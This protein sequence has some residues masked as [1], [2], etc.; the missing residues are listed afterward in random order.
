MWRCIDTH[1][2]ALY[3][4]R[5][6]H[7]PATTAQH[8]LSHGWRRF[9]AHVSATP[10]FRDP[11]RRMFP[12]NRFPYADRSAGGT[13]QDFPQPRV[14]GTQTEIK[15]KLNQNLSRQS[16]K[17]LRMGG[18]L[19]KGWGSFRRGGVPNLKRRTALPYGS[20]KVTN[21]D[22]ARSLRSTPV[23]DRPQQ[24]GHNSK[25]QAAPV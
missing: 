1:A 14:A 17:S 6:E 7:K 11:T 20:S 5:G 18:V 13:L 25:A 24:C 15:P 10:V 2:C 3:S 12:Y 4:R 21:R 16:S 23:L 22:S 9:K 8:A 19:L